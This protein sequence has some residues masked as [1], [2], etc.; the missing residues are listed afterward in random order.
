MHEDDT[1]GNETGPVRGTIAGRDGAT[2]H[3]VLSSTSQGARKMRHKSFFV[4]TLAVPVIF[5]GCSRSMGSAEVSTNFTPVAVR[6]VNNPDFYDQTFGDSGT[7]AMVTS[8]SPYGG[9][10]GEGNTY[11]YTNTTQTQH[12]ALWGGGFNGHD[13]THA[14]A[15][16]EP[17]SYT[18][19]ML[20]SDKNRAIQGWVEVG[21]GGTELVHFL[22]RW[23]DGVQKQKQVLAYDL[24][25]DGEF[26]NPDPEVYASFKKQVQALE[27]IERELAGAINREMRAQYSWNNDRG[28]FLRSAEILLFPGQNDMFNPTTEAVFTS[29]E[30]GQAFSGGAMSKMVLLADYDAA[31]WKLEC[32]NELTNELTRLKAVLSEEVER[33]E[34]M[35]RY[36]II[37][38]HLYNHGKKFVTNEMRLQR[39]LGSIDYL[40]NQL[41]ELRERRMAL[42]FVTG[43][44]A[45]E[46]T[47]GPLDFELSELERERTVMQTKKQ[48]VDAEFAASAPDSAK[49]IV[50]ERSRQET[51]RAIQTL[52]TQIDHVNVARATLEQMV[53]ASNVIHRQG[54]MRLLSAAYVESSVPFSVRNA[55]S[56]ESLMTV[57][58]QGTEN[59][60]VPSGAVAM[61]GGS[62]LYPAFPVT[63]Q[64]GPANPYA[65]ETFQNN[66]YG[67]YNGATVVSD[68]TI[69][70]NAGQN[71]TNG[72]WNDTYNTPQSTNYGSGGHGGSTWTSSNASNGSG[73][74]FAGSNASN[75][76]NGNGWNNGNNDELN[77]TTSNSNAQSNSGSTWN[78]NSNSNSGWNS[79]NSNSS[80]SNSSNPN[81]GFANTNSAGPAGRGWQRGMNQPRSVRGGSSWY[82][83]PSEQGVGDD[84]ES[85]MYPPGPAYDT[86]DSATPGPNY[87]AHMAKSQSPYG[88]NQPNQQYAGSNT[89][90]SSNATFVNNSFDNGNGT[91]SDDD[92]ENQCNCPFWARLLVPPCWFAD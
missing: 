44:V 89:N 59:V 85:A 83:K 72:T 47:F 68:E 21:A 42:A 15:A 18:F 86:V 92:N 71:D 78:S 3:S 1:A 31:Q 77:W 69:H 53:S 22:Q 55:I 34:R 65:Y 33:L 20:A 48:R 5:A 88:N 13:V 51:M 29:S 8:D 62:K 63:F 39:T 11:G 60:H 87:N 75:S 6:F 79:S 57:R 64:P 32:V 66:T 23:R 7:N 4:A 9:I 46:Y 45:P 84:I 74:T 24:E 41:T 38:D 14:V 27:K 80:F 70:W 58:L 81:G 50:L 43:L 10:Q 2:R 54:D 91:D 35:K 16:L 67:T 52:D 37:T 25:I 19:A 28:E 61:S 40:N 12:V 73:K 49:R 56:Q 26:Q 30:V 17:G 36:Y 90:Q 76:S 82:V